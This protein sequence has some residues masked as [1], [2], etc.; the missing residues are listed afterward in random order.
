M[1]KLSQRELLEEGFGS[2]LIKSLARGTA[3]MVKGAAKII[4][5]TAAKLAGSALDKTGAAISGA[6]SSPGLTV[7]DI[8]NSPRLRKDYTDLK[9]ISSD[10]IG[11]RKS[12]VVS[13][14]V[15]HKDSGERRTADIKLT[16]SDKNGPFGKEEWSLNERIKFDNG[17]EIDVSDIIKK[18]RDTL[19]GM[20]DTLD[21]LDAS[22]SEDFNI[23]DKVSWKTS[24]G[25]TRVGKLIDF[26]Q[27]DDGR[28]DAYIKYT[29]DK[30]NDREVALSTD[31]LTKVKDGEPISEKSQK[32]LLKHLQSWS[33]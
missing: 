13:I 26:K 11:D 18:S 28:E 33:S 2:N 16:R 17:S 23:D 19:K 15:L 12:R 5:P 7:K 1:K 8:F 14:D 21:N 30:G 29:D 22:D 9:I 31:K 3:G 6:I 27:Q 32:S 20:Q 10:K 24:R 25:H 4:S